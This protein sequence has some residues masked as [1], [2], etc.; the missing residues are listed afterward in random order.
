MLVGRLSIPA[1]RDRILLRDTLAISVQIPNTRFSTGI[2]LVGR[3]SIP[4]Q[5]NGVISRDTSAFGVQ[6]PEIRLGLRVTLVGRFSIPAHRSRVSCATP[7]PLSYIKP[8]LN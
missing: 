5:R 7:W 1:H 8:R 6:G 2:V 4:D 3:L